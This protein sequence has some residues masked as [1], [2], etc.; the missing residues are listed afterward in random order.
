M[1]L[2]I[3]SKIIIFFFLSVLNLLI[4]FIHQVRI[5]KKYKL[6]TLLKSMNKIILSMISLRL[7]FLN[8][9]NTQINFKL[10]NRIKFYAIIIDEIIRN[11]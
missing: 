9:L 8:F 11:I 7:I 2:V 3:I 10:K 1:F 4:F 6:K 5:N